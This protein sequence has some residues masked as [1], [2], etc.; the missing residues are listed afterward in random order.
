MVVII[1]GGIFFLL[2]WENI[3]YGIRE[4]EFFSVFVVLECD[5]GFVIYLKYDFI[6]G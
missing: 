6:C 2:L 4:C 5:N 3:D 1:F